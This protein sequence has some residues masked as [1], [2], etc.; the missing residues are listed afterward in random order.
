MNNLYHD[1]FNNKSYWFQKNKDVD[2]YLCDKYLK[3][4]EN[5]KNIIEYKEF[6]SKETL[7]SCILLLD[8]IPRHYKRLYGAEGVEIDVDKYSEKATKLINYILSIYSNGL[9][10]DELSFI[11]L[12][13]RHIKNIQKIHEI[14]NIY[15]N[16]Y[17]NTDSDKLKCK[18]YLTATLNNIYKDINATYLN[19]TLPIKE[20]HD[21]DKNIFDKSSLNIHIHD[22]ENIENI[23]NN[24]VYNTISKELSKLNNPRIIVSV[25]GGVD[26][27]VALYILNKLSNNVLALHINY[28]N[29]D[30]S[31][32]ELNYV[33]YF[34]YK[35]GIK[36]VYRTITEIKRADCLNNGLREL[37]EDI[38]KKIRF[39][40]YRKL[41]SDDENTIVLLGHNKDDCFE[42]II[43]NITNR[44]NYDNLCGM[45]ILKKID[46]IN[47]WR[48]MLNVEKK[49]IIKFANINNIPYL[50]DS[51]PEWS[52]RGKIRDKLR[53]TLKNLNNNK[54]DGENIDNIN[55]FFTLS[56]HITESYHIINDVIIKK[57]LSNIVTETNDNSEYKNYAAIYDTETLENLK[58]KSIM[59]IFLNKLNINISN[60]CLNDIIIYIS[61]KRDGYFVINKY[62][63]MKL[64]KEGHDMYKLYIINDYYD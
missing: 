50:C 30:E 49:D 20:W 32:E 4:I 53:H 13:Y 8:Q 9:C 57:L 52:V 62:Y 44:N 10:I 26:S 58:Y 11:L 60:K 46:E 61:K 14:V 24:I 5:T 25:S 35:L 23:E 17:N 64:R 59:K 28:N 40:M 15:I 38:T 7:I 56:E 31:L 2:K 6:Y 36:L 21:I 47:F 41:I 43:T 27:I 63:K 42:N 1:W 39:D 55:A 18:R 29:R 19:C 22:I 48:P 16:I 37:Y 12:P 34:C 51:T 54:L 45:E 3:Y 33:N